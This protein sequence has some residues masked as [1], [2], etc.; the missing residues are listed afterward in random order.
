MWS[1]RAEPT[2]SARGRVAVSPA[3]GDIGNVLTD[4]APQGC[5]GLSADR[6]WAVLSNP[7]PS[8]ERSTLEPPT[9]H[10]S[11][12]LDLGQTGLGEVC[13]RREP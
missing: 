9:P 2:V 8:E 13:G 10:H 6:P 3:M 12:V 1:G 4:T 11:L 7:F 5:T